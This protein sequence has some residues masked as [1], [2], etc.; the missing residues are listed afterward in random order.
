MELIACDTETGG[1]Y[2]SIHALLSIC[3]CCGWSRET[4]EV[5]I[6]VDS[7]P[8]KIVEAQAAEKN[9]YTLEKWAALGAVDLA[10][11]MRRFADWVQARRAEQRYAKVVCHHLAFDK[12]FLLE[13]ERVTGIEM[14]GRYDWRCSLLKLAELMDEGVIERGSSSL[15]RL[16]ELSG[17]TLPRSEEHNALQDAQITLHGYLW[18]KERDKDAERAFSELASSRLQRVR[19]LEAILNTPEFL[20]F[21]SAVSLEAARA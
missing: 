14:P 18:L 3:A 19:E 1:F 9:G 21:S 11:A 2:P 5:Y 15:D 8:G 7:Q 20:D 16:K 10:T 4:F 12:A 6:T 17:W 13:A